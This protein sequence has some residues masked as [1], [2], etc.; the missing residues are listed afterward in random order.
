MRETTT[1]YYGVTI[2]LDYGNLY[3]CV[4]VPCHV[5]E[6]EYDD[7]DSAIDLA[8]AVWREQYGIDLTTIRW[9]DV[10][11]ESLGVSA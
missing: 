1:A 5:D 3:T 6:H 4:S 9:G 8:V 7:D 2:V 11:V 10:I